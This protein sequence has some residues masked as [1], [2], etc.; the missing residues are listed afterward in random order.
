MTNIFNLTQPMKGNVISLKNVKDPVFSEKMIGDGVAIIPVAE[1][2]YA[3]FNGL[4]ES[5]FPTKHAIFLKDEKGNSALLHVGLDT[6]QLKGKGFEYQ[7]QEGQI[8]KRG[9]L[10]GHVNLSYLK[11]CGKSI[12]TMFVYPG[13]KSVVIN[14]EN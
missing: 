14:F 1:E 8:I 6:V 7:I 3:P 12:V 13:K 10:L 11:E 4:V 2:I 5:I 9:Q